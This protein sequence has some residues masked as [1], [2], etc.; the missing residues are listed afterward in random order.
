MN[1]RDEK[2]QLEWRQQ[3]LRRPR[4]DHLAVRCGGEQWCGNEIVDLLVERHEQ[5]KQ[6]YYRA[7]HFHETGAQLD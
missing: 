6:D 3:W 4:Y 1:K 5:G 2:R 7:E